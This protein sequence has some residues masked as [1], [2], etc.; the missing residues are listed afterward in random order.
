[1]GVVHAVVLDL[2]AVVVGHGLLLDVR[3]VLGHSLA[4]AHR[5][6]RGARD[7]SGGGLSQFDAPRSVARLKF[8]VQLCVS[9]L[10]PRYRYQARTGKRA[11]RGRCGGAG[12]MLPVHIRR[13]FQ[14]GTASISPSFASP[15]AWSNSGEPVP[16]TRTAV[17]SP[18]LAHDTVKLLRGMYRRPP[19]GSSCASRLFGPGLKA[20]RFP[21]ASGSHIAAAVKP[22]S[23]LG[24]AHTA[25][26]C[27][28]PPSANLLLHIAYPP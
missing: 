12:A 17:L 15:R 7:V 10:A 20:R 1:V 3:V 6:G 22:T 8:G 5:A 24:T 27:V 13:L 23:S 9:A 26:A 28:P 21:R 19:S 2:L 4:R 25:F 11:R 18:A 14:Q 16:F